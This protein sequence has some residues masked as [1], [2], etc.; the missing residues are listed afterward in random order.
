MGNQEVQEEGAFLRAVRTAPII[1]HHAHPLLTRHATA[2]GRFPLQ[3]ITTEAEGSALA[4]T[5]ASLA[6]VRAVKQ[7]ASVLSCEATWGS[8]QAALESK[9]QQGEVYEDWVKSC[10]SSICTIL[11]DDSIGGERDHEP[12]IYFNRFGAG[13]KRL[14]RIEHMA[15]NLINQACQEYDHP[16]M[17]FSSFIMNLK[18]AI[19]ANLADPM[20]AGFK[21]AIYCRTGLGIS[22]NEDKYQAFIAFQKIHTKRR[23][24][25]AKPFSGL[26]DDGLNEYVVHCLASLISELD[27]PCTK[28]IQFHTSLGDNDI[29]MTQASPSYLQ[30]FI[31]QYPTVPIILL[32]SGYP[33][34]REM[35]YLA[36]VYANVYADIG[37]VFPMVSRDGQENVIR[38]ILELCP[39]SKVLWSTGGHYLPE[40]HLLAVTQMRKAFETVLSEYVKKEDLTWMEARDV[41]E[42][43]LFRNANRLYSLGLDLNS[44][45]PVLTPQSESAQAEL[46]KAGPDQEEREQSESESQSD[47]SDS[48][49]P[50]SNFDGL[51]KLRSAGDSIQYVRLC[52]HDITGTTR[53]RTIPIRRAMSI[54]QS[55]PDFK[56]SVSTSALALLQTDEMLPGVSPAKE[57]DLCAD[58]KSLR[59]G[60]R[61]GLVTVMGDFQEKD[62]SGVFLCPRT[63]LSDTLRLASSHNLEFILGFEIEFVLLKRTGVRRF[64]MLDG[65]AHSWCSVGAADHDAAIAVEEAVSKLDEAGIYVETIHPESAFG[66]Y[67][68]VL[69]AA[70]ALEAVDT[71]IFARQVLSACADSRGYKMTLHPKP[72]AKATGTAAHVHMSISSPRGSDR[73][74]WESFYAG[75]LKHLRSILAYTCAS[76]VSYSRL[77]DGCWAGGTWVAWGCQNR[78]TPLRKIEDSHWELKCMDGL[79]N[80]YLAMAAIFSA[81]IDGVELG[82]QL[83]L[84][85][86]TDDPAT[87]TEEQRK[88]LNITEKLPATLLEALE[89]LEK[90][91]SLREI[92]G[93]D[94]VKRYIAVKKAEM[95]MLGAMDDSSQRQWIIERY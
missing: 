76:P 74:T 46:D 37:L 26:Q 42:D 61:K 49:R 63:T 85:E 4:A 58:F 90:D 56:F 25:E 72:Y 5:T 6:H 67:E 89:S 68:I 16:E 20:V 11:V 53:G 92:V 8:V 39:S 44:P 93:E 41:V 1:D 95:K 27:S 82:Q 48:D 59:V 35:G 79:A 32:H 77:V 75:I 55:K 57:W 30:S 88:K 34:V 54:L 9:R 12:Y 69:P 33:F 70:P 64:E 52:W 62:G 13:S 3:T 78:E 18:N 38:Q 47:Q 51:A 19:T 91:D 7:L 24:I 2:A 66:Q 83:L 87:L 15:A 80:P 81:G 14:V 23:R 45:L 71:L 29:T 28:P 60:P 36:T 84:A 94:S 21:S 22:H 43:I 50:K 86:C 40:T 17:A 73:N 10:L 65:D 31:K